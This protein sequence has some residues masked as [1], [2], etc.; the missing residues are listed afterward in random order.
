MT[1]PAKRPTPWQLRK[2]A[3]TKILAPET[4][5][6][7]RVTQLQAHR[8]LLAGRLF[9]LAHAVGLHAGRVLAGEGSTLDVNADATAFAYAL[10]DLLRE[11][12]LAIELQVEGVR[13]ARNLFDRDVPDAVAVRDVLVHIDDYMLGSGKLQQDARDGTPARVGRFVAAGFYVKGEGTYRLVLT[14]GLELDV[15]RARAA[16]VVLSDAVLEQLLR[17][18]KEETGDSVGRLRR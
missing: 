6:A 3:V 1:Q 10:R 16:A 14:D 17:D 18:G 9:G 7:D 11:V 15:A 12:D 8:L 2:Q 13:A 5:A 4:P